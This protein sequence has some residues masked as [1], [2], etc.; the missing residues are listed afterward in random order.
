MLL[1]ISAHLDWRTLWTQSSCILLCHKRANPNLNPD[2]HPYM[3][4]ASASRHVG[5][6]TPLLWLVLCG[7]CYMLWARVPRECNQMF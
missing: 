3:W 4:V 1:R 2:A 7:F 5:L 6:S